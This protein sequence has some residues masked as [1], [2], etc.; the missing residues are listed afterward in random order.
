M[1]I[2]VIIPLSFWFLLSNL[3]LLFT[4]SKS[5]H[6]FF[7]SQNFSLH[8][9]SRDLKENNKKNNEKYRSKRKKFKDDNKLSFSQDKIM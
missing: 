1:I 6:C 8:Y 4:Q 3:A 5:T 2:M 7:C 9:S